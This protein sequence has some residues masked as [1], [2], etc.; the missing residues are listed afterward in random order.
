MKNCIETYIYNE[1]LATYAQEQLIQLTHASTF[2]KTRHRNK[3]NTV[4]FAYVFSDERLKE[5][6]E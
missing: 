1:K 3:K 6:A 5:S 4:S 2:Q